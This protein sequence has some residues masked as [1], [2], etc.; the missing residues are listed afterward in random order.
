M[1]VR[2]CVNVTALDS[3]LTISLHSGL[4]RFE[5]EPPGYRSMNNCP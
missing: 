2:R 5:A 4:D 3:M 1:L